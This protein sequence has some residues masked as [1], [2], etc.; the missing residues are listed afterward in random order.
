MRPLEG[1]LGWGYI[2]AT[3]QTGLEEKNTVK[4]PINVKEY[5]DIHL[6]KCPTKKH[7]SGDNTLRSE[8]QNTKAAESCRHSQ[9]QIRK[10]S[11]Y[12]NIFFLLF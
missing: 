11:I 7:A 2:S 8:G 1:E 12:N 3:S 4:R 5:E 9:Q 6:H 10:Y